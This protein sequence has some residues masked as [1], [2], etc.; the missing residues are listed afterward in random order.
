MKWNPNERRYELSSGR[1]FQVDNDLGCIGLG[2]VKSHRVYGV[3]TDDP[4]LGWTR[5]DF[6]ELAEYMIQR[7]TD[8]RDWD[9]DVAWR[10]CQDNATV[11]K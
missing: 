4:R 3:P 1:S 7:W 10:E 6:R 8:W 9:A 5:E 11:L 2:I